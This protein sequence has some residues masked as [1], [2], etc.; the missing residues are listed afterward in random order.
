MTF[1]SFIFK[2]IFFINIFAF[3]YAVAYFLTKNITMAL[4][5]KNKN[6]KFN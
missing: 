2:L 4:L 3:S 1:W 5:N 6:E